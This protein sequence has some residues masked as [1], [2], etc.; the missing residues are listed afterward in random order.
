[1]CKLRTGASCESRV[2]WRSYDLN[3]APS[4]C[5]LPTAGATSGGRECR[6]DSELQLSRFAR[7]PERQLA[8]H[9][10]KWPLPGKG[11]RTVRAGSLSRDVV[12]VSSER[13]R[14]HQLLF[15]QRWAPS[16]ARRLNGFLRRRIGFPADTV[17]FAVSTLFSGPV[18]SRISADKCD[19]LSHARATLA[20]CW[21]R[22]AIQKHQCGLWSAFFNPASWSH[23][24]GSLRTE[25]TDTHTH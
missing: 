6:A 13:G 15:Y 9:N 3:H 7:D 24:A 20:H 19:Q 10:G 22:F 14:E 8:P 21:P 17:E 1:M 23:S 25:P 16:L 5:W 18:F 2:A 4:G 12:V 11:E